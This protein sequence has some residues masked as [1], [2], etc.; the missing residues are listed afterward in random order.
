MYK[1]LVQPNLYVCMYVCMYVRMYVC[2]YVCMRMY[3]CITLGICT[4]HMCIRAYVCMNY[5]N[6]ILAICIYQCM[7]ECGLL[8]YTYCV[9]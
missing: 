2:M 6:G 9:W 7:Y 5:V 1:Y 3:E 4:V 8:V